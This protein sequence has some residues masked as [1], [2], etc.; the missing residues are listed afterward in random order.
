[1]LLGVEKYTETP[2]MN[3]LE[4]LPHR[5][6]MRLL[7]EVTE[8]VPGERAAAIRLAAEKDFYFDG[9]F[10]GQSIVPAIILVEMVAQVGGLAAVAP[11]EGQ[12]SDVPRLRIAGIGPFKFPAPAGP[13]VRLEARARVVARLGAMYKIEGEVLADGRLVASGSVTLAAEREG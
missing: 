12:S 4:F 3:P 7:Q 2:A 11:V 13:G 8:L 5:P 6:P 9:H 1:M 10:P